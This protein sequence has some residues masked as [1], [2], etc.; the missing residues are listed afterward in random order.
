[1]DLLT[2]TC[3][4]LYSVSIHWGFSLSLPSF[5]CIIL[6]VS[7]WPL[8]WCPRSSSSLSLSS[9]SYFSVQSFHSFF[10]SINS[11]WFPSHFFHFLHQNLSLWNLH[12]TYRMF[13][14]GSESQL[15]NTYTLHM[16]FVL[17]NVC[18]VT[19]SL[20]AS[21]CRR[22]EQETFHPS[23]LQRKTSRPF[24][25]P[26]LLMFG[27]FVVSWRLECIVGISDSMD[28]F[29]SFAQTEILID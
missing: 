29:V 23:K 20:H 9:S 26:A 14:S 11:F 7:R 4:K 21:V 12:S 18:P 25:L 19:C 10:L 13:S 8:L 6:S 28:A 22:S 27:H 1:M 16:G 24:R 15:A 2:N 5:P 3:V 17:C